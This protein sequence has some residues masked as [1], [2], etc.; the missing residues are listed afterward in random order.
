MSIFD[1]PNEVKLS[2]V[3]AVGTPFMMY[4]ADYEGIRNTAFGQT[5]VASVKCGAAD[6]SDEPETYRVFG[7]LAE[8]IKQLE[9]SDL[10]ALVCIEKQGRAHNWA[11]VSARTDN[12]DVIF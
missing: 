7:R 3:Y 8:Q 9:G 10:P 2:D 1:A 4:E 6:R 12:T 11:N 5:H